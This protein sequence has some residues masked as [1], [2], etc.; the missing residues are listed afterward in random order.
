MVGRLAAAGKRG[1]GVERGEAEAKALILDGKERSGVEGAFS[2][3][4]EA[5]VVGVINAD[6][7]Y[8]VAYASG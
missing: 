1:S 6:V 3:S 4:D 7:N 2:N 8:C 5:H